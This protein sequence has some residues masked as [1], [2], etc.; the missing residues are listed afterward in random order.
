[1]LPLYD[2]FAAAEAKGESTDRIKAP[3]PGK[4]VQVFVRPGEN[5]TRGQPLAILE[6][7]KMEHTL[8]APADALVATVDAAPGDQVQEGAVILRFA[9]DRS[10]AA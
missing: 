2:P 7:M 3:M 1:Q 8:A 10:V 9:R 4:I 6:A 5:V